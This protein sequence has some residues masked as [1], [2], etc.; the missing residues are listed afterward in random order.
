MT[1]YTFN[2]HWLDAYDLGALRNH[3]EVLL[4]STG[5]WFLLMEMAG[6]LTRKLPLTIRRGYEAL[7]NRT[8]KNWDIHL[9]AFVHAIVVVILA[10]GILQNPH[11]QQHRVFGYHDWAGMTYA[12]TCG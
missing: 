5:F 2:N 12:I 7:D 9:V 6:P 3:W 10:A 8:K 4:L 11:L 1:V